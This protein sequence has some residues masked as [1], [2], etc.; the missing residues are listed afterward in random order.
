MLRIFVDI[1]M[2]VVAVPTESVVYVNPAATN[3]V[4]SMTPL[5]PFTN[6]V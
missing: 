2:S 4:V 6:M 3:A 5:A 1:W